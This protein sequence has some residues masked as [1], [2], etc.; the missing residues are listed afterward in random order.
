[1][2]YELFEEKVLSFMDDN[3]DVDY[4][5]N[6]VNE[7]LKIEDDIYLDDCAY[8]SIID[9][10][11]PD[12]AGRYMNKEILES[13]G[14]EVDEKKYETDNIRYLDRV[15][16]LIFFA[17]GWLE[18]NVEKDNRIYLSFEVDGD[19]RLIMFVNESDYDDVREDL[20][21]EVV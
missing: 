2:N 9:I 18:E 10:F 19:F 6:R 4:I 5:E 7:I 20:F 11:I 17:N 16:D 3:F 8:V 21:S 15:D 14:F 13:F 12:S 1:M